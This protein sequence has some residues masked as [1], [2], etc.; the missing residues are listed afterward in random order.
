[1]II[2][3]MESQPQVERSLKTSPD[4]FLQYNL[5]TNYIICPLPTFPV[6]ETGLSL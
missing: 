2:M 1:M 5:G 4:I 3:I 6:A